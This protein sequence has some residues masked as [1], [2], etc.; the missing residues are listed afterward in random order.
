[1]L[2]T[3]AV[4]ALTACGGGSSAISNNPTLLKTYNDGTAVMSGTLADSD[5]PINLISSD[6]TVGLQAITSSNALS[7]VE[8][9]NNGRFYY[10]ERAGVNSS[11]QNI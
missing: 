7:V 9:T 5:V 4:L 1:M 2:A 11:G 8:S 3:T 10:V 6:A